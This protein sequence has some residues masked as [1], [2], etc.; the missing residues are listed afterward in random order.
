MEVCTPSLCMLMS[1]CCGPAFQD[2]SGSGQVQ[3]LSQ[4]RQMAQSKVM[5]MTGHVQIY[6]I[7]WR[8]YQGM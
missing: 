2:R 6:G 7:C 4:G 8:H 3:S 5:I 1:V